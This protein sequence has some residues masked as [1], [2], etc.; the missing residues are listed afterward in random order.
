M[1]YEELFIDLF[2]ISEI[3]GIYG[4]SQGLALHLG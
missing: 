3:A 4:W 2:A 1:A